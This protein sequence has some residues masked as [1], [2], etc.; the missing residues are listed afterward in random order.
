MKFPETHE[1]SIAAIASSD[2]RINNGGLA[3]TPLSL[4]FQK[5]EGRESEK[6]ER[7]RKK[8]NDDEDENVINEGA[9]NK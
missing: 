5:W 8:D 6:D 1:A 7:K 9:E 2:A 4:S 3:T